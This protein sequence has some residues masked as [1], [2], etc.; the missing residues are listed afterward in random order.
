MSWNDFQETLEHLPFFGSMMLEIIRTEFGGILIHVLDEEQAYTL[1]T[2][3]DLTKSPDRTVTKL[4]TICLNEEGIIQAIDPLFA[5]Y[6]S[7][8]HPLVGKT[9]T[10]LPQHAFN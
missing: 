4:A 8:L 1:D 5:P 9:I 7:F 2:Y 3:R 10:E 6:S